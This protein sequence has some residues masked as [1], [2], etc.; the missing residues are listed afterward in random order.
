MAGAALAKGLAEKGRRVLVLESETKFKDRV[1]GEWLAPWGV[2]EAKALGLYDALMQTGHHPQWWEVRLGAATVG[3]RDLTE[4]TPQGLHSMTFYHPAA[5][6]ALLA[7]AQG[8]GAEVRRGAR[9]REAKPGREPTVTFEHN[10]ST[11]TAS[12]RLV[13]GADGRGSMVRKWG[14]FESREDPD[15]QWLAGVL[16]EGVD[17]PEDRSVLLL[18][19]FTSRLAL[20]FPQGGGKTRCYFG[21]RTGDLPRLQGEKDIPRFVEES[22]KAGVPAAAYANAKPAGPLATFPGADSWV[23]HPYRDGV[24][25]IG[26]AAATSDQTWGQGMSL[27]LRDARVLRDALLADDDWERAGNAY[28]QAHQKYQ[29][30]I[31]QVEEWYTQLFMEAGDE[32][33]AR[34][35][36]ALPLIAQDPT[37]MHDCFLSGPEI[38]PT[39]EAARRR[40]FGEE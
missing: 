27:A 18:N 34:R 13:V 25:L 6:E 22:V 8:A 4:T 38:G 5:Q 2:A 26:D 19:P 33:T 30:A 17:S 14:G 37:R 20:L 12:A 35:G 39:D 7:A 32:A 16:F 31:Y 21:A 3:M 10:G 1:R 9:V 24:A 28:A 36:R 29:A 15:R 23:E 11:E 40:F